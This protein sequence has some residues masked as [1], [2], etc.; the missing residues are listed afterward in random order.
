M[1]LRKQIG[2]YLLVGVAA[3]AGCSQGDAEYPQAAASQGDE[4][5]PPEPLATDSSRSASQLTDKQILGI[6]TSVDAGEIEQARYAVSK[7]SDPR[8]RELAMHMI[9][10][11]TASSQ[12]ITTLASQTGLI[13]AASSTSTDLQI[14]STK[15]LDSL[16]EATT[17]AFDET[18][19]HALVEQHQSVLALLHA[20][21]M[22]ASR[23]DVV[24]AQLKATQSLVQGHLNE[25]RQLEPLLDAAPHTDP[26][27]PSQSMP[28]PQK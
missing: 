5:T 1:S 17:A 10:A 25:A 12:K 9:D 20:Q 19:L 11:H 15:V 8:V 2:P 23:S 16:K 22:P 26:A 6:L 18:Y 21:L 7:S 3:L 14:E 4:A 24:S 27:Q 28:I 13:P